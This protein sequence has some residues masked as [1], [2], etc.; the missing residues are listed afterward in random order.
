MEEQ[1]ENLIDAKQTLNITCVLEELQ[2]V[3]HHCSTSVLWIRNIFCEILE[4]L[5]GVLVIFIV[6]QELL[7]V[8]WNSF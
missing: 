3:Q 1:D 6:S 7:Y 8:A 2:T 4:H 5:V